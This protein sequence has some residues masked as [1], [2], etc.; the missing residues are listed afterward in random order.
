MVLD[1]GA[2]LD[3]RVHGAAVRWDAQRP[4]T[5]SYERNVGGRGGAA[6]LT[7]MQRSVEEPSE[8]NKG[9]GSNGA[10]RVW[11]GRRSCPHRSSS[12]PRALEA[13]RNDKGH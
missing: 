8:A 12:M 5:L 3:A 10:D 11:I 9:W 6:E 1:R 13:R 4:N 7:V 2:E